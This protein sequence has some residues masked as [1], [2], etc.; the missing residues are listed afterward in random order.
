MYKN[1]TDMLKSCTEVT[2]D[3]E[4]AKELIKKADIIYETTNKDLY[5]S[6]CT[7]RG[8]DGINKIYTNLWQD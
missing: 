5:D 6:Y 2:E 7:V 4:H 8:G 1:L 3:R